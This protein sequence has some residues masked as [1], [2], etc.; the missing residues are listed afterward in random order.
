MFGQK[1][2][3][4]EQCDGVNKY[5]S[6]SQ[7]MCK[8]EGRHKEKL[9]DFFPLSFLFWHNYK[10]VSCSRYPPTCPQGDGEAIQFNI[11]KNTQLEI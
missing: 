6:V 8:K 4:F 2:E 7:Y 10:H 3:D 11:D 5:F 1:N 9:G